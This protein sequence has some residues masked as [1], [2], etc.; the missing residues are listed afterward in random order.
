[1]TEP[2][3]KPTIQMLKQVVPEDKLAG[4]KHS[5]RVG[6]VFIV[7]GVFLLLFMVLVFYRT[8]TLSILLLSLGVAAF[9]LGGHIASGQL[10]SGAIQSLKESLKGLPF[11]RGGNGE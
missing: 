9:T 7:L 5:V 1:M 2:E 3:K 11:I 10:V 8:S 6:L 4:M